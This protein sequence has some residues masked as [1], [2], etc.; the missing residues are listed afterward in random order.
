MKK[1][2]CV[3]KTPPA[4]VALSHDEIHVWCAGVAVAPASVTR[5]RDMLSPDEVKRADRI[6]FDRR[7][8]RFVASRAVLRMILSRYVNIAPALLQFTYSMRGKPS[9]VYDVTR[10]GISFNVAHSNELALYAVTL[11]RP[12]GT[13]IE[14]IRP[15]PDPDQLARRF[16]TS[17]EYNMLKPLPADRKRRLFFDLWTC[18]EAYL[19]ATGRGLSGLEDAEIGFGTDK[20]ALI[21]GRGP[22]DGT[23]EHWSLQQLHVPVSGYS[24]AVAVEGNGCSITAFYKLALTG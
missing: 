20:R 6:R 24:A 13:D 2:E 21:K 23:G 16:F 3:W 8:T 7:R 4:A 10:E 5:F 9:L 17:G 1:N 12:I 18:K 15:G 22:Q 11:R 14:F 19:K